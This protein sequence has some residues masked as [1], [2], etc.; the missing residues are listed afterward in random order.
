VTFH[1]I[2]HAFYE[3]AGS[4]TLQQALGEIVRP[5]SEEG[6]HYFR[7]WLI[8]Q[9]E[10]LFREVTYTPGR[11]CEFVSARDSWWTDE[12]YLA[13]LTT[14]AE[15]TYE[16]CTGCSIRQVMEKQ[17]MGEYELEGYKRLQPCSSGSEDSYY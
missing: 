10:D 13:G 12:W 3:G 14:A 15:V 2:Y 7:A 5:V 6:F 4:R 17:K 9:G 1:R 16:F 8:G 11:L